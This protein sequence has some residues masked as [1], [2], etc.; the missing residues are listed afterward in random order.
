MMRTIALTFAAAFVLAACG[1]QGA[2]KAGE[3]MDSAL[4][5]ATQ[6]EEKLGD[7]AMENAGEALDAAG[8]DMEDAAKGAE[9]AVDRATDGDPTTEP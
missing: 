8:Q 9:K 6:G 3:D 5:E 7:G 1:E 2:E 4:E